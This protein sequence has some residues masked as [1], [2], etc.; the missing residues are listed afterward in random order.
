MT[1]E[2]SISSKRSMIRAL[3]FLTVITSIILVVEFLRPLA[4]LTTSPV[5]IWSNNFSISFFNWDLRCSFETI[6][7]YFHKTLSEA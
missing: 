1:C 6:L 4:N 3:F 2:N 5:V 7:F